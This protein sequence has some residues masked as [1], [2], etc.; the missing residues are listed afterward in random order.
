MTRERFSPWGV[1]KLR[2]VYIGRS[3]WVES[4]WTGEIV[5]PW[6]IRRVFGL[7]RDFAL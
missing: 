3:L 2:L 5:R 4:M 6:E 1:K 7:I